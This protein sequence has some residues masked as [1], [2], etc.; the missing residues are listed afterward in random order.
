MKKKQQGDWLFSGLVSLALILLA[1]IC[2][3]AGREILNT[4]QLSTTLITSKFSRR[5]LVWLFFL[6]FNAVLFLAAGLA[7]WKKGPLAPGSAMISVLDDFRARLGWARWLIAAIWVLLPSVVIL[8]ISKEEVFGSGALRFWVLGLSA[9]LSALVLTRSRSVLADWLPLLASLLAISVVFSIAHEL[10][11]VTSYPFSIGWSEG[12]RFYDYSIMFARNLY[13]SAYPVEL[14]YYSPGRYALWGIVFLFHGLPISIHRLW[15]GLLWSLLPVIFGWLLFPQLNWKWRGGLALWV[16][17]YLYQGPIYPMLLIA[18]ILLVL[19][20]RS[21]KIWKWLGTGAGGL[22]AGL[23]RWTWFGSVGVWGAIWEQLFRPR[24]EKPLIAR[25]LPAVMVFLAG[26]VPGILSNAPRWLTPKESTLSLS[27]PLLWYRLF[28]NSTYSSGILI[29]L[30]VAVVP[31][32]VCL[33]WLALTKRWCLDITQVLMILAASGAF[34]LAGLVASTKIG[35]GSNLHNLDMFF[36]T[37]LFILAAALREQADSRQ[38]AAERW[39]VLIRGWISL[40][41]LIPVWLSFS[42]YGP[43]VLPSLDLANQYVSDVQKTVDAARPNGE[44]LFIDQRQ[45]LT[46]GLVKGID[47]VPDYEKKYM[48]DQAMAGNARYFKRFYADLAAH[49]FALIITDPLFLVE[50]GGDYSF[51][52]ENNAYVKWVSH[53]LLCYYEIKDTLTEVRVQYLIPRQGQP[54]KDVNCP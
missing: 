7:A 15:D 49:R 24:K 54:P 4:V 20:F 31:L 45:L 12:N 3:Q 34:L 43:L 18:A 48:M 13:S 2:W 37:L 1:F 36:I 8:F 9:L 11:F 14:P 16:A 35:G 50:Q 38:L 27:Q 10:T 22:Y 26:L 25:Y 33:V 29:N 51:G 32:V 23:S 52:E 40:A 44:V 19:A 47:L 5:A 30:A 42:P 28:P 41:V 21:E 17:L 39:P 46:F 6:L 53:P